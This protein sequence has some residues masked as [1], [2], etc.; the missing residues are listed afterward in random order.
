MTDFNIRMSRKILPKIAIFAMKPK[1]KAGKKKL[2]N[3]ISVDCV[4]GNRVPALVN[5]YNCCRYDKDENEMVESDEDG[6]NGNEEEEDE[7]DGNCFDDALLLL[8]FF[9]FEDFFF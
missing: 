4:I 9:F 3:R 7:D 1:L 5:T 6:F 2:R 8:F